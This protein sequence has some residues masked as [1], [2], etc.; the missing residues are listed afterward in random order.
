MGILLTDCEDLFPA[1]CRRL[2]CVG[3]IV[4][5]SAPVMPVPDL[6]RNPWKSSF[7]FWVIGGLSI[8]ALVGVKLNRNIASVASTPAW[9]ASI[10]RKANSSTG[11][12]INRNCDGKAPRMN[13]TFREERFRYKSIPGEGYLLA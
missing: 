3:V 9:T 10:N 13:V 7:P 11:W 4:L 1:F 12:V 6:P 8:Y 2:F 5:L